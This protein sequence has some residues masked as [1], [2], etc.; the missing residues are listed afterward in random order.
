MR[1]KP[2]LKP[3]NPLRGLSLHELKPSLR[4]LDSTVPNHPEKAQK[5]ASTLAQLEEL[6]IRPVRPEYLQGL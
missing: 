3:E 1:S 4:V 5:L 2:G 6:Q